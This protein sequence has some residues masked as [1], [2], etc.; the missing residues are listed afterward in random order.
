MFMFRY[1]EVM[2]SRAVLPDQEGI[3]GNVEQPE[4]VGSFIEGHKETC[5]CDIDPRLSHSATCTRTWGSVVSVAV[6]GLICPFSPLSRPFTPPAGPVPRRPIG[7][8]A[9]S[10]TLD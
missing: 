2:I 1:S 10:P 4:Q 9:F 8:P 7:R 6:R 3:N 5:V